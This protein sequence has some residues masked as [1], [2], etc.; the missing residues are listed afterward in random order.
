MRTITVATATTT[1]PAT[2]TDAMRDATMIATLVIGELATTITTAMTAAQVGTADAKKAGTTLR[3]RRD[4]R[5]IATTTAT[6]T[7]VAI[8]AATAIT[9]VTATGEATTAYR[10]ALAR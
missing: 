1:P 7:I 3:F 10:A 9:I 2:G 8:T 4:R 5:V 6:I